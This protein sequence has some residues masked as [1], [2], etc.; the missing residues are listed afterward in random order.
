MRGNLSENPYPKEIT[1]ENIGSFT[2]RAR[3]I[4]RKSIASMLVSAISFST[5]A[6]LSAFGL[7]YLLPYLPQ[8]FNVHTTTETI[9]LIVGFIAVYVEFL[10]L[11]LFNFVESW[12]NKALKLSYREAVLS[13]CILIADGL[14]S[15]DIIRARRETDMFITALLGFKRTSGHV[16]TTEINILSNG[17]NQLRKMLTLSENQVPELFIRF[18]TCVKEK[19]DPLAYLF[20]K[21]LLK[22]IQRYGKIE[23]TFRKLENIVTSYKGL[24]ALIISIVT[25]VIAL[26]GKGLL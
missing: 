10:V 3:S 24:T 20:L 23:G 2:E 19:D 8:T 14:Y 11:I 4:K 12:V 16:F 6:M 21:A 9:L 1:K 25:I 18:G 26:L 7:L 15:K 22:E 13:S 5:I 17:K